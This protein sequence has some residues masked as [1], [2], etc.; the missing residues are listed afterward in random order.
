MK[1]RA[2]GFSLYMNIIGDILVKN[3]LPKD[4]KIVK[5]TTHKI[6]PNLVQ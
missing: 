3:I 2:N 5:L 1:P 6:F 4:K